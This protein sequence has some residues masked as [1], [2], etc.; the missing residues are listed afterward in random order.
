MLGKNRFIDEKLAVSITSLVKPDNPVDSIA[1]LSFQDWLKYNN[2]LFT[3]ADDFLYR[4]QSYLNNWYDVKNLQKPAREIITKSL[5]TLLINEIVLSFTSSDERR[6]LK[7][8]D[9]N[10]NRDLAV[11]VPFFAKKVKD[12][13]LYYS[14]L[15]DDVKTS[16]IKY[17]LKGSIYGTESL[18]YNQISKS[19]ETEDLTELITSL[20]LSLSDIRN[21][22]V[23]DIEELF[24]EYPNYYDVSPNLPASAYNATNSQEEYFSAN[25]YD[26]DK[27][28]FLNFFCS[29]SLFSS[30]WI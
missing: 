20:N 5:Y 26:I 14:T 6:F 17:N 19:L 12:I 16:V 7:N 13:C 24:D 15:R 11:A 28:L 3:N 2:A 1:P 27:T 9:F 22:M 29:F 25:Q 30:S 21:N 8:I 4:Y 23:I 10:N 18:I